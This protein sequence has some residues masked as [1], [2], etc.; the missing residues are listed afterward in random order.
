M[1]DHYIKYALY[2]PTEKL[3]QNDC[4][5]TS[6]EHS[7]NPCESFSDAL[8]NKAPL[9]TKHNQIS[10]NEE[11]SSWNMISTNQQHALILWKLTF[12]LLLIKNM[13]RRSFLQK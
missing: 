3:Y 12:L 10:P 9:V 2:D 8:S 5:Y 1:A 7:C 11:E 4:N 13:Q 6:H